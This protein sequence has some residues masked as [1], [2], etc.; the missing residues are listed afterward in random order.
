MESSAP[1]TPCDNGAVPGSSSADAG[2]SE[3]AV[4]IRGIEKSFRIGHLRPTFRRALEP[5][6]FS[7]HRGEIL[8]Y[9]GP[10]GSGKTTTLK[11]LLGLLFP[12][13]GT[14]TILGHPLESRAWRYRAGYLPEHPYFYDYLTAA[15]YLDYAG[16][17]FGMPTSV[18]RDRVRDVLRLVGLEESAHLPL[19]R[20]SKGMTQRVGLAQALVNDPEIVL[21]DEPMSGLDP[22]GRRLVRRIILDLKAAGKT[23]FF[24][25]HILGDAESLCDRVALLR[26]G[27]LLKV[28]ALD[29][30]LTV[31]VS[32]LEVLVSGIDEAAVEGLGVHQRVRLGDRWGL[33][34]EESR[35][36]ELV[37]AVE[38]LRGRVL[39]VQPIRQSLEEYFVKEMGVT[40]GGEAWD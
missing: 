14:A 3:P 1:A 15:E 13:G 31:D 25:T 39:S 30:I 29:Q 2:I 21:L 23:V 36:G 19:R 22:L 34:V 17:L 8:G 5:L 10:N 33:E 6:T 9:L 12:D 35:L 28:G 40:G 11:I 26:G 24:S 32:H 16:R 27:K 4:D 7:I 18:R 20:Y 37:G 38:A